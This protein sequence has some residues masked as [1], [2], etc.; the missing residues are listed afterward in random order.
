MLFHGQPAFIIVV[1]VFVIFISKQA[2][3]NTAREPYLNRLILQAI[4]L[5]T[6][7]VRDSDSERFQRNSV[8][9]IPLE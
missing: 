6:S 3:E 9:R 2:R 4:D 1:A 7:S 8:D 5:T